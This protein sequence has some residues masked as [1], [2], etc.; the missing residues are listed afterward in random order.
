MCAVGDVFKDALT[1]LA[2]G[3]PEPANRLVEVWPCN[4]YEAT[5]CPNK[6]EFQGVCRAHAVMCRMCGKNLSAR[7]VCS[8]CCSTL[9]EER[10]SERGKGA[11]SAQAPRSAPSPGQVLLRGQVCGACRGQPVY[12]TPSGTLCPTCGG[13]VPVEDAPTPTSEQPVP[14]RRTRDLEF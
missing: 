14:R 6:P 13:G 8:V 1:D 10:L 5:P 3:N 4:A 11:P 2:L 12:R 9:A 7:G